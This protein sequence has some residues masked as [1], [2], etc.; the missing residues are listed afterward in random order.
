MIFGCDV[1]KKHAFVF[2]VFFSSIARQK[3]RNRK[4]M[5]MRATTTNNNNNNSFC[6][7]STFH[8]TLSSYSSARRARSSAKASS[9]SSSS[10][11]FSAKKKSRS[12]SVLTKATTG[13]GD[14]EDDEKKEVSKSNDAV[15]NALFGRKT[16]DEED[17]LKKTKKKQL[18]S[19]GVNLFDPAATLSRALTKRFGIVGGLSLVAVLALV[20]GGEIVKSLLE[21][22]KDVDEQSETVSESG[23]KIKDVRIG[24][25][26]MPNKGNFVG[27][28]VKMSNAEDPNVVYVDTKKTGKPIAFIYKSGKPLLTPL[29]EGIVEGV[30]TMKRGGIR[31]LRIPAEKLGFGANDVVLADGTTKIPGGTDLFV[32]LELVDVT[33]YYQ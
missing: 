28:E 16:E 1:Q 10:S 6:C 19:K 18:G 21:I 32:R 22:D 15:D 8:N 3:R 5:M 23:L 11:S 12:K 2:F 14:D 27:V 17:G 29:C 9:S 31:E 30:S 7:S 13:D 25:G 20:E 4:K 24:G 33:S 26:G